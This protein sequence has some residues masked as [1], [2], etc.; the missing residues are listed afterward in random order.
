MS[1]FYE[2]Q[3]LFHQRT[4]FK[5]LVKKILSIS[6]CYLCKAMEM[7]F[8]V[9]LS[10]TTVVDVRE[11]AFYWSWWSSLRVKDM[12]PCSWRKTFYSRT[13]AIHQLN[14]SGIIWKVEEIKQ[15]QKGNENSIE[16][17]G[18]KWFNSELYANWATPS[19]QNLD[20]EH[21]VLYDFSN[22]KA[23]ICLTMMG[24]C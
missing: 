21:R 22:S 12:C 16:G 4:F 17:S 7:S 15:F 8:I 1:W 9:G 3:M 14:L 11:R 6:C 10:I 24:R 23:L 20:K 13:E 19:F 5:S 2:S 18:M